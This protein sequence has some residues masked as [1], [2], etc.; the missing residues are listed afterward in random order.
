MPL[1]IPPSE[2]TTPGQFLV[3]LGAAAVILFVVGGVLLYLSTGQPVE[4]AELA[5]RA[6]SL[7]IKAI[8]G[9]VVLG[10]ATWLGWRFVA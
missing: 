10:L 6:W 1:P 5:A 8:I 9:S 3:F 4:K 2:R 7:G